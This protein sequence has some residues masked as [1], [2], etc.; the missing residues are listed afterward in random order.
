MSVVIARNISDDAIC[1]GQCLNK[2]ERLPPPINRGRNDTLIRELD[3][4]TDEVK[5]PIVDPQI[6]ATQ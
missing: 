4:G 6:K 3:M 1:K 2:G 5:F